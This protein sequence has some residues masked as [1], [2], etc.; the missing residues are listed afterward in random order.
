MKKYVRFQ[1]V[2]ISFVSFL[3][4]IVCVRTI[5]SVAAVAG[6][7]PERATAKAVG[8]TSQEIGE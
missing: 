5:S 8:Q 7:L 1:K 2:A 6:E 3:L 4:F